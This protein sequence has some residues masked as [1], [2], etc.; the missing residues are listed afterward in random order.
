ME[1]S[2]TLRTRIRRLTRPGSWPVSVKVLLSLATIV[3]VAFL[4]I[5][6]VNARSFQTSLTDRIVVE[7]ET[8]ALSSEILDP[9]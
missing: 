3:T 4:T 2:R 6:Y 5:T 8:L 7:F 9:F 1:S